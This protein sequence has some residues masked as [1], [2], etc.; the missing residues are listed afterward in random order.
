MS[1][2][3]H[4]TLSGRKEEFKP[5]HPGE[6]RMY[7]CGVTVYDECHLGHARAYVSFDIIRRYL[8]FCGYKVSY[9]RNVTDV[10]DKI[11]DK[12]HKEGCPVGA[13]AQRYY[14]D[15]RRQMEL[16]GL[17]VPDKEPC[18]TE[19]IPEMI[20]LIRR[21]VDKGVAY[22]AGGDVY[23][24]IGKFPA[25][26]QLSRRGQDQML[27]GAR[28]EVNDQKHSPLD[29]VLWKS[30]KPGEPSWESPWGIGRPG[31]HIECSAMSMK[32]LG[33]T[34]DLHGGGQDLIFPHHEN[35]IAQ[36]SAATDKPLARFW[37]HN[38]FVM[39]HSEKMSKSLGNIFSLARLFELVVPSAVR[40]YLLGKH[41][42]SPLDFQLE[43]VQETKKMLSK[44]DNTLGM[45]Q[46]ALAKAGVRWEAPAVR[47]R[48][49]W[50]DSSTIMDFCE[51]MDDD[52]NTSRAMALVHELLG[53]IHVRIRHIEEGDRT[54]IAELA[55]LL[56]EGIVMMGVLGVPYRPFVMEEIRQGRELSTEEEQKLLGFADLS[57]DQILSLIQARNWARKSKDFQRADR[58]RQSLAGK[59]I[60]LRDDQSGATTWVR[61]NG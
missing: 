29:F 13:I 45:A 55:R 58:I 44:I 27:A 33:E 34:F 54:Q 28:V 52:F 30:A 21:L 5:L 3:I 18:A 57:E 46:S 48:A 14:E 61:S 24:D 16:L 17:V 38:G 11:I 20:D 50:K 2:R 12:A 41:Y 47:T 9:V 49:H 8:E 10:D 7:V 39:V 42:R 35:E 60:I 31:W 23:F 26:G 4:N 19:H 32:Y 40:L 59:G 56:T 22:P 15:F 1:L 36:S 25:Y 37:V 51:A 53:Q 6:V 43:E